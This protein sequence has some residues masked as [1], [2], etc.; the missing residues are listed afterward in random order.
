MDKN[1]GTL[2]NA[3]RHVVMFIYQLIVTLHESIHSNVTISG[4]K[5]K[6]DNDDMLNAATVKKT[7]ENGENHDSADSTNSSGNQNNASPTR[8]GIVETFM[9]PVQPLWLHFVMSM[10][11]LLSNQL[12]LMC[13]G[14]NVSHCLQV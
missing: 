11:S 5:V 13:Y 2:L 12:T 4:R 8:R 10:L 7:G 1:A 14:F 6:I 9:L 3:I